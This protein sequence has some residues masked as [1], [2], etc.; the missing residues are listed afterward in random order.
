M[1]QRIEII[2]TT[3]ADIKESEEFFTIFLPYKFHTIFKN[4]D[5]VTVRLPK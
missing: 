2:I 4:N 5:K 3:E 1:K